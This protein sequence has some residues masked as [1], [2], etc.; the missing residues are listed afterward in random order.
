MDNEEPD[1]SNIYIIGNKW[2]KYSKR[3]ELA[4]VFKRAKDLEITVNTITS[5]SSILSFYSMS[6]LSKDFP[7]Y[8]WFGDERFNKQ[9]SLQ[10]EKVTIPTELLN[11]INCVKSYQEMSDILP[12]YL[13]SILTQFMQ[14]EL[15]GLSSE[16][17]DNISEKVMVAGLEEQTIQKLIRAI[18]IIGNS[19]NSSNLLQ[20]IQTIP[21]S[22]KTLFVVAPGAVIGLKR[23]LFVTQKDGDVLPFEQKITEELY[24][25]YNQVVLVNPQDFQLKRWL[26]A[27]ISTDIHVV[28][29]ETEEQ[30][31]LN[32]IKKIIMLT[33][34]LSS[35]DFLQN[36]TSVN[37]MQSLS[38]TLGKNDTFVSTRDEEISQL[39][40]ME[41]FELK[42]QQEDEDDLITVPSSIDED[43]RKVVTARFLVKFAQNRSAEIFGTKFGEVMTKTRQNLL[44]K[45]LISALKPGDVVAYVQLE[46]CV[47][48]YRL[49]LKKLRSDKEYR[50][51]MFEADSDLKLDFYWKNLLLNYFWRHRLT[52]MDLMD[53]FEKMDYKRSKGFFEAWSSIDRLVFVP[54][55][56]EFIKA[57]G[58]LTGSDELINFPDHYRN[59]STRVR[60]NFQKQKQEKLNSIEH[61]NVKDIKDKVNF[62]TVESLE[63]TE[64]QMTRSKTNRVLTK[65]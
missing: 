7:V 18:D 13:S 4:N 39:Q 40:N 30:A 25:S 32:R 11:A 37:L 44:E 38:L 46:D 65:P 49:L 1:F 2:W 53:R 16:L 62:L 42:T 58:Q 19:N 3:Q 15:F 52:V 6:Q 26:I 9:F 27:N 48:D 22:S 23:Q 31:T 29:P 20:S 43:D 17:S 60:E 50:I 55:D 33:R 45:K 63:S 24:Q 10:L 61:T 57:L 54:Q 35:I 21:S 14:I 41:Q 47:H 51:K 8:S 59:A 34:Q 28:I 56:T 5:T 12:K 36:N 64:I